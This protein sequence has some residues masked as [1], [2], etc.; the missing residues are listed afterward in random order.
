MTHQR[1]ELARKEI[2]GEKKYLRQIRSGTYKG[3]LY[4]WGHLYAFRLL[5]L[6]RSF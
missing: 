1:Q 4:L 6:K 3:S 5:L 2:A